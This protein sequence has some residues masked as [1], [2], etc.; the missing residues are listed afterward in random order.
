MFVFSLSQAANSHVSRRSRC[1]FTPSPIQAGNGGT[2]QVWLFII[3]HSS[4]NSSW[5]GDDRRSRE[6]ILDVAA[7]GL[8]QPAVALAGAGAVD[9]GRPLE[10]RA[11]T[12]QLSR[13]LQD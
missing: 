8:D 4:S 6:R 13:L 10:V 3:S 2:S 12:A 7:A 1:C 9:V 5:L 11:S